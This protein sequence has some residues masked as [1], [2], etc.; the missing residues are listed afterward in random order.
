L[1]VPAGLDGRDLR[2][3]DPERT[4]FT[5]TSALE[6]DGSLRF[7]RIAAIDRSHRLELERVDQALTLS[8]RLDAEVPAR[9][10]RPAVQRPDLLHALSSHLEDTGGELRF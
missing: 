9:D 7:D 4:V 8:Q 6:T 10:L 5:E 1:P 2:S 3:T